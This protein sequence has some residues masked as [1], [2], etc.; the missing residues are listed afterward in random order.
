MKTDIES[1]CGELTLASASQMKR[2]IEINDAGIRLSRLLADEGAGFATYWAGE[3]LDS[4]AVMLARFQPRL[5]HF[6]VQPSRGPGW[7][8]R[9]DAFASRSW[10]LAPSGTTQPLPD[11][12]LP[13]TG[14]RTT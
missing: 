3:F 12:G 7:N 8:L 2:Q 5:E 14:G 4:P 10:H 1:F 11:F 13:M 9:G 6:L